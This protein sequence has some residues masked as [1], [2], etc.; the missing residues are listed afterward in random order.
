MSSSES[1]PES[2][3]P[4]PAESYASMRETQLL[5]ALV[6]NPEDLSLS[7]AMGEFLVGQ[8]RNQDA[9]AVYRDIL[10]RDP[11]HVAALCK[12]G[13]VLHSYPAFQDE[14]VVLLRRAI[15][16]DASAIDAYRPL[17]S[18]LDTLGRRD[19][20]TDVLRQWREAAPTDP[21]AEHFLAA[22]TDGSPPDRAADAFVKATFDATASKFDHLLRD[23]LQYRAPEVLSGHLTPLLASKANGALNILDLGC[24][25]GLCGPLLRPWAH[26]L[27]GVDL[28]AAMLAKAEAAGGYDALEASELT[29]F[30]DQ[31]NQSG[32]TFDLLFA[33][34][35]LIYFGRLDTLLTQAFAALNPGGWLAFTVERMADESAAAPRD[36]M[37]DITG[38]YKHGAQYVHQVLAQAGFVS[39][40]IAEAQIRVESNVPVIALV[41]AAMKPQ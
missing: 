14:A 18:N 30:L 41:V 23:V 16:L 20:A 25:T 36:W 13:A 21:L 7:L 27:T 3:A 5:R 19:E 26:R 6:N 24:G 38:R 22:Y 4:T 28:S 40:N 17:A 2:T 39:V 11:D 1:S 31:S 34:D 8:A 33:T 37:L 32:A 29:A 12:L 10:D 15:A 35:T 9:A